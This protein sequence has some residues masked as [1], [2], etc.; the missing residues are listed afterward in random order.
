M[1]RHGDFF[2]GKSAMTETGTGRK[3]ICLSFFEQV[4]CD[5]L[6]LQGL[7]LYRFSLIFERDRRRG[8][9]RVEGRPDKK[10]GFAPEALVQ[11]RYG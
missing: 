10:T 7:P 3:F 1:P 8:R 2:C 9:R 5:V 4:R 6:C 11:R